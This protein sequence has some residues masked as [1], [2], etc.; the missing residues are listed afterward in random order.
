VRTCA[1]ELLDRLDTIHVLDLNAGGLLSRRQVTVDGFETQFQA[2]HLGHFLLTNLLLARLEASAPARVAVVSSVGHVQAR[3]GLRFDDLQWER[4]P[5]RGSAVYGATKLM[6]ILFASE[7]AR[8]LAGTNVVANA[9]HPGFV[10]SRFALEGDT[11][12]MR[13]GLVVARPFARS[14]ERG[15]RG[16]IWLASSPEAEGETG[17]YWVHWGHKTRRKAPSPAA[18]DTDA[19]HQL[20]EVSEALTGCGRPR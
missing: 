17:G 5:Y 1:G 12:A 18:R 19:A 7:L 8:R 14:P 13:L 6:N 9:V 2:N 20:W 3:H 15:A 11:R 10:R 4:R 16:I